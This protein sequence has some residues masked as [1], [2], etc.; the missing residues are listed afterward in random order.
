[1]ILKPS[2]KVPLTMH[3]IANLI[4]E[5][6][7]P[8]GIFQTVNGTRSTVEALIDHPD[9]K[10][11]TF[12]GT[13]AVAKSVAARAQNLGKR[14]LC[15][16]GAKN[17]LC[18]LPDAN[19]EMCTS[20][21]MNSFA[22]STGQRCMAAS[23]LLVVGKVAPAFTEMLVNKAKALKA[24]QKAGEIGP[25]IDQ[26]SKDKVLRYINE[27]ESRD[28]AQVLVDGRSWAE[29]PGFWV[30]PTILKH[31]SAKDAAVTE[32]I[33]GPVLSVVEVDT[34]DEAI[35]IENANPYGNAACIY[36]SIG[37]NA[38]YF[39][40]RFSAAMLGVNIGVPVPR[41][42]FSFGGMNYSNMG[43]KDITGEGC[44]NFGT[45]LKKITQKWTP[46]QDQSVVTSSFI[47]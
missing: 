30:G 8:D 33:F 4:K 36:T 34:W 23:V 14:A 18:V 19:Y 22:G 16:G 32:E 38:D 6:G 12:V 29:K 24:G 46:P 1:V 11:I 41:E 2:E 20:D 21:V 31:K 44:M 43:D 26:A 7:I 37:Q 10:G 5:A 9:T 3:F 13:S 47:T 39:L 35:A 27:A 17:H 25:L 28:G 42:P 15:L 40:K 45:T